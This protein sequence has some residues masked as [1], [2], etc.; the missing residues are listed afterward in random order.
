MSAAHSSRSLC[1]SLDYL[2][3]VFN[4]FMLIFAFTGEEGR[5]ESC[6]CGELHHIQEWTLT[7]EL[8]EETSGRT[9]VRE[10]DGRKEGRE[11]EKTLRWKQEK[12]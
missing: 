4:A 2:G 5:R 12:L 8:R 6:K 7:A 11:W 1:A 10:P 9:Y 3:I